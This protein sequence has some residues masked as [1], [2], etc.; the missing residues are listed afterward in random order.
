MNERE[1]D[2]LLTRLD[3]FLTRLQAMTLRDNQ[4]LQASYR[5]SRDPVA[6]ADR[7]AGTY[8]PIS[9]GE[10]WGQAWDHAWFHLKGRV[11]EAWQGRNVV[12]QIHLNA[13]GL[14][15]TPDGEPLQGITSGSIFDP[16]FKRDVVHLLP[17]AEGGEP[18][19]LWIDASCYSLLGINRPNDPLPDDSDREGTFEGRVHALRLAVLDEAVWALYLDMM[20][21]SGILA[22]QPRTSS[23]FARVLRALVEAMD[24]FGDNPDNALEARRHLEEP[25]R[26]PANASALQ[27]SAVGHAHIDTGWLWPVKETQ[28]KCARTFASQLRLIER[29]PEY[30]FGASQA[31]HYAFVRDHY[32]SLFARI[33]KAVQAGR[34]ECQG[35]MWVEADCNLI[36]GESMIRQFLH[37][38]NF[39]KDTFGVDVRHLWLPDV[40]GYSAAMPQIMKKAGCDFFVTQKISWNQVNRFPHSTFRWRGL[41]GTDIIAHF[42]PE[43]NYNSTLHPSLLVK[44]ERQFE[45]R[46]YLPGFLSLFGVGDGGGGPHEE[47]LEMGRRQADL[48]GVPRVVYEPAQTFLDRLPHYSEKLPVWTGELYLEMHRGTFTTQARTK[49]GNRL[50]ENRLR[51]VEFL[52]SCG[53]LEDYPSERLDLLWKTLLINQFHD[54]I[55]G[56]SIAEVYAVTEREHADAIACCD[57]WIREAGRRLFKTHDQRMTLVNYLSVPHTAIVSLPQGWT[58]ASDAQ[59]HPIPVQACGESVIARVD[60]P[61]LASLTLQRTEVS[62]PDNAV[63]DDDLVLENAWVRYE[64]SAEGTLSRLFDKETEREV[65]VPEQGGNVLTLYEDRP[66]Q[67]DAWDVDFFYEGQRLEQ[68]RL[69]SH[70]RHPGGPLCETLVLEFAIGQ[71]IIKQTVTLASHS[72]RLDFATSVDWHERH[73]MLRVSFAVDVHARWFNSDIQY[74][75]VERPTHRNTSWDSARFETVAHRYVDL[76]DSGYG[77][78]L[79]N[80]CKYG[81]KVLDNLLDLNLLR[82]PTYP[83]PRADQGQHTFTYSLLPHTGT[84]VESSVMTEAACLNGPLLS[85]EGY[86]GNLLVPCRIEST[87][88]SLEVIKKAEK[89]DALVIRLVETLGRHST[90]RLL[91]A[92]SDMVAIETNLME[93]THETSMPLPEEGLCLKLKPFEIKTYKLVGP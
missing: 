67:Y 64:F 8:R 80:D 44:G 74:G 26:Q 46:G 51:Q 86:E 42:P 58:G 82:A 43:D 75:Y 49:R 12:A 89:E 33:Q 11:P 17:K 38:K 47:H 62:P 18:I 76:S 35:G 9:E 55:P 92:H 37:G 22:T 53:E 81:H 66:N 57:A 24:R 87:G 34:W 40:F 3:L 6:F 16:S 60:V 45:E 19:E 1:A 39:F 48:E 88:V 77:V 78:A 61:A 52:G 63:H 71:S 73:K 65:L 91:P 93:W 31:Q 72:K 7:E 90:C 69:I 23:R 28:R 27:A 10:V 70:L 13:E 29:Y 36:S 83:D 59:G 32:P 79:L 84:L 68:A 56:S 4:P 2:L 5:T 30:V 85:F 20:V 14:V 21:L 15:F 50:L 54:I 25:L 41:D